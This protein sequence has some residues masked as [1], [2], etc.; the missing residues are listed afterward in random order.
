MRENHLLILSFFFLATPR[1]VLFRL[2]FIFD[3][4]KCIETKKTSQHVSQDDDDDEIASGSTG[5]VCNAL[6]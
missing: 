5:N 2:E 4:K 1:H 6:I 3:E